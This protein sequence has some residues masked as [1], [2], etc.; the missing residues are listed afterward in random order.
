MVADSIAASVQPVRLVT[1]CVPAAGP[2]FALPGGG[3]AA[4]AAAI[5]ALSCPTARLIAATM[6]S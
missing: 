3:P 6:A 1:T 4:M 5:S 2:R